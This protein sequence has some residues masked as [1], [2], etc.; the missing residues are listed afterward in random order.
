MN[1]EVMYVR[2]KVQTYLAATVAWSCAVP[3]HSRK[4][5]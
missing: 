1:E 3:P 4:S 2:R 5:S